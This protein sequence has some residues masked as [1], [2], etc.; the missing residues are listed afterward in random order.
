L[1][2]VPRPG[3]ATSGSVEIRRAQ[4][5]AVDDINRTPDTETIPAALYPAV[6]GAGQLLTGALSDR[7]AA[8]G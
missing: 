1:V 4:E 6:W 7:W 2:W 8:N 5:H 3:F